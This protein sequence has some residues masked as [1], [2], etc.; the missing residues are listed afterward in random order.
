M[1]HT[2]RLRKNEHRAV[3]CRRPIQEY[4]VYQGLGKRPQIA[5][6]APHI[7][8]AKNIGLKPYKYLA[9]YSDWLSII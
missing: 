4:A 2:I 9:F 5:D 8:C 3:F 7:I 6:G 1:S